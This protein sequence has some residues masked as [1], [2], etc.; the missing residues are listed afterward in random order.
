VGFNSAYLL[1]FLK[2]IG[3]TG[4]VRLE[5]KD[6]QRT[7]EKTEQPAASRSQTFAAGSYVIRMDQPFSRIADALLDRQYW[8]PDDPQKRP[9]DDTGWSFGDLFNAK[10]VRV[11]DR[12]ILSAKMTPVADPSDIKDAESG[13][14]AVYAVNNSGQIGL[15]AL[16]YALKG[17]DVSIA[18][19]PFESGGQ[20]FEAGSI[21]I[22]RA[23]NEGLKKAL[24]EL[25]L[26]AYGLSAAPSVRTRPVNA[27]RI[28]F[29]HTWLYTQTEG[30]WRM[31][32]DKLHVPFDY[33][34]TQ[35]VS[36]EPDL[37]SKYDVI[38]FGPAGRVSTEQIVNG[39]PMWGNPLPWQNTSLTPNL[40]KLDTTDDMR[41][42]LGFSGVAN[43]KT[44]VEAGG[45]LIT[46]QDT[47]QFA[48]EEGLAPGVSVAPRGGARVVG[49][50]LNAVVADRTHPIAYGYRGN[51]AVYS[52]DGMAFL[53]SNVSTAR[54]I[55]TERDFKR[56]TGRGG[57]DEEDIPENRP[58]EKAPTLPS[59]KPWEPTPLNEEQERNNPYLIPVD[60]RPNVILRY[61]EARS[62][63]LSGLLENG[64]S[65][66]EHALVVNAHLGKGNVL[67]F[68]NNPIYRGE[69]IGTYGLVFNAILNFDRLTPPVSTGTSA[70]SQ[71]TR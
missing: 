62:L 71:R 59:P 29:V 4:E 35:T 70:D 63:L 47:S 38:I 69:T 30:W 43:L 37:R 46:A 11:T 41:P 26:K 52:Q 33:I 16:V 66:A 25:E 19:E 6:A 5:F 49:S 22:A 42:G 10:A 44:F 7:D 54:R 55:M 48:I 14:G 1:D 56:P 28:A 20:H 39:I 61:S 45:L 24:K 65:I 2:A 9:Y 8:A 15:A 12:A 67:L 60:Q 50:V 21:L 64:N 23:D 18:E 58:I 40:G 53:V 68:A 51:V 57:P 27:P 17:A 13:S 32:F 3:N 31:A 36:R 34:S